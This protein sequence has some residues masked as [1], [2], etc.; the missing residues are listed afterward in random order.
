MGAQ[1]DQ[2]REDI[3][4]RVLSRTLRPGDRIDEQ[5]LRQR[6]SLSGTPIREALI[7]LETAGVIDRRPRGGAHIAFLDLEQLMKMIE[8]LA[9]TE[10][11][12]AFLAARRI[13]PL[14]ANRLK[15]TAQACLDFTANSGT[16]YFDLNL[17]FHRALIASAGNEYL[18]QA[19]YQTGN[20]L[21]AYLAERHAL[22]GEAARSAQDHKDICTAVL[23]ADGP[24]ARDLMIRHVSFST[25]IAL[26][27]MNAMKALDTP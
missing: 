23:D 1:A 19:V 11:S 26:D 20:R 21:V 16:A 22:P 3:L 9:E 8:V 27:V 2:V 14:Q 6:L 4:N 24:R 13:N 7:S 18:E 15:V 17:E 12:V 5:E 10:G 25:P